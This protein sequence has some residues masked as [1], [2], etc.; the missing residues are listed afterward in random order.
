MRE[1]LVSVITPVYNAGRYL[2]ETIESVLKQTYKNIEFI[3]IDDCSSDDS[4]DIIKSFCDTRIV[5]LQNEKNMGIEVSSN[6]ALDYC[7][8]EYIIFLDDDDIIPYDRIEYQINIMERRNDIIVHGGGYALIDEESKIIYLADAKYVNDEYVKAK[9]FF[10]TCFVNGSAMCRMSTIRENGIRFIKES[11]GMQDYRFFVHMAQYG[12]IAYSD[13]ALVLHRMHSNNYTSKMLEEKKVAREKVF[14]AVK[15]ELFMSQGINMTEMDINSFCHYFQ[16]WD[17]YACI[18]ENELENVRSLLEK[19]ISSAEKN[20][21]DYLYELVRICNEKMQGICK[22]NG[23]PF[24]QVYSSVGLEDSFKLDKYTIDKESIVLWGAGKFFEGRIRKN[25]FNK[26]N[27]VSIV[28]VKRAGKKEALYGVDIIT[29]DMLN[30]ISY[31]YLIIMVKEHEAV[32]QE[33]IK[34]NIDESKVYTY[35]EWMKK[36]GYDERWIGA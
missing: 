32:M 9:L 28:D 22:K 3:I 16:E 24:V 30:K 11:Y 12:R 5:F 27:I 35:V 19:I 10:N 31:D 15:K 4:N 1:P 14:K 7:K 18:N 26:Y 36:Q 21:V 20:N 8:G 2:R 13:K 17:N 6:K 23:L 33:A 29:P 25:E 34:L